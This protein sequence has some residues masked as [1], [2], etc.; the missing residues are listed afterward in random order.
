[1]G[2]PT[3]NRPLHRAARRNDLKRVWALLEAGADPRAVDGFD[4]TFQYHMN[5]L[6][7]SIATDEFIEYKRKIEAW[8]V[9]HRVELEREHASVADDAVFQSPP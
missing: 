4:E 5:V 6:D 1:M 3:G 9:E 2:Q 8:L 7:E